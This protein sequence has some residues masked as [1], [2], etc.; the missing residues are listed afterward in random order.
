MKNRKYFL[1]TEIN[2]GP[3][4]IAVAV[5]LSLGGNQFAASLGPKCQSIQEIQVKY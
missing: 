5:A 4:P 2:I 3:V 1:Y